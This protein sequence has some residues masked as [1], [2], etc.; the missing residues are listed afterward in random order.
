[1]TR[2][3]PRV[4]LACAHRIPTMNPFTYTSVV[5]SMAMSTGVMLSKG[6]TER[7][8]RERVRPGRER[9]QEERG[10]QSDRTERERDNRVIL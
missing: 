4:P 1:M 2:P 10:R 8:Y 5:E 3:A 9:V 6:D 7:G